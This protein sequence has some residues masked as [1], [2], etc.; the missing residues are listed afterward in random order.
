MK[1]KHNNKKKT[2]KKMIFKL[3]LVLILNNKNV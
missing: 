1:I 3:K 2:N